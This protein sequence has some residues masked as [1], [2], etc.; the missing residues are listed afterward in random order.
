MLP[1]VHTYDHKILKTKV[2]DFFGC[3]LFKMHLSVSF[4]KMLDFIAFLF[5]NLKIGLNFFANLAKTGLPS[6][7]V[8]KILLFNVIKFI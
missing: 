5:V 6:D 7:K 1:V 2:S 8:M 3:M 4:F